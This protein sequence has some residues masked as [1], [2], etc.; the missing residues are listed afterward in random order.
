MG[1]RSKLFLVFFTI[2]LALL[3]FTH[4][5][6]NSETVAF[7]TKRI[8][9]QLQTTQARFLDRFDTE[10]RHNLKLVQTITSDQKYRSFLQ[11]MRDNYFSFA[12]EIAYD[13]DANIVFVVDET[14]ALR[15]V[16]PQAPDNLPMATTHEAQD[17]IDLPDVERTIE[18]ILDSGK[19]RRQVVALGDSLF[20]SVF[21]PLK[22]SLSDDY[23]LGV[24]SVCIKLDDT[25]VAGLMA[26]DAK[27]LNVIFHIDGRPVTSDM[28]A[29]HRAGAV[30][31]AL[32]M[33]GETGTIEL[34]GERHVVLK[35]DFD[36]AGAPAG[37]VLTAS[38]DKAMAPFVSLQAQ[39][40]AVGL[41]ALAI[42]VVTVSLL[43]NRI[44]N[45][46]RLLVRGTRE[47]MTGNYDYHVENRSKDE[48]GQLA[49]AFNHM[50]G[51]L[52]EREQI[53]SLFGKYVHPS[54]VKDIMGNP[55]HLK[56]GGTRKMQTM[57]F[58]D[59]EGF[60]SISESMDAEQLVGFLN[61]Y[62]GAMTEEL[63]AN[64]GILDK[65]LG[66][67]IMAFWGEPFTKENHALQACRAALAMQARLCAKSAEW[68]DRGL[69]E[70][71][72]RIGI[73]TGEVVVGN[74]GSDQARDYTCIGDTVN[75]GSRL[76]GVN[77][78]YGTR[79]IID[80]VSREMAGDGIVARELDT[81]Q[82]MGRW[83]GT[84]IF[85][86]AGLA[87]EV[88]PQTLTLIEHYEQALRQYRAGDI[89]AASLSFE[90]ILANTP[91]DGPSK[92]MLEECR[93]V[94]DNPADHWTPVRVL[95]SK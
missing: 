30:Q 27:D 70:L 11:Q 15:G 33:P 40:L 53:R 85:E 69:P 79:I 10:S 48:V 14:I 7:E 67:G 71:R 29:G 56:M 62:L 26:D 36:N 66:D 12:E 77:R 3:V 76:E 65:Y 5:Y 64:G 20:N 60:T 72:M 89:A 59:I 1:L 58:S 32:R 84:R 22:E 91:N 94:I 21:V 13:T 75:L 86:L 34:D 37:Y 24:V 28:R 38:L 45:P 46:I 25:W 61:D 18:G 83:E 54:I 82:V 6:S 55:E 16:F 92:A 35:G 39:I 78:I 57:L 90:R 47:V 87:G 50:I 73:A 23:A 51:G 43:T 81:V 52:K 93:T 9:Q 68:V 63:S 49:S 2:I 44:V 88:A 80:E 31:A 41:F 17:F 74:I 95:R 4:Y 8:T 42:G 19:D